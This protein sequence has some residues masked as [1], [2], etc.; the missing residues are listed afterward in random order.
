MRLIWPLAVPVGGPAHSGTFCSSNWGISS[1]LLCEAAC[2]HSLSSLSLSLRLSFLFIHKFWATSALFSLSHFY[3]ICRGFLWLLLFP[4]TCSWSFFLPL[5]QTC[6]WV[7]GSR[8]AAV[9]IPAVCS[10]TPSPSTTPSAPRPPLWWRRRS[11]L[12]IRWPFQTLLFSSQ[13]RQKLLL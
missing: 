2:I 4:S 12:G 6:R 1:F 7:N 8:T 9:G 10:A 11:V 5:F 13:E 3:W